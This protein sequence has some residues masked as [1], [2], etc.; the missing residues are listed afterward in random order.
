M[1]T[2]IRV[3]RRAAAALLLVLLPTAVFG[4][5]TRFEIRSTRE[6]SGGRAF[7][8]AGPYEEVRGRLFFAV[9]PANPV[10]RVVVDLD[11]APKVGGSRVEFSAD[12]VICRPRDPA[13]GNGVALIDVVN[14]GNQTIISGFNRP[15]MGA[16]R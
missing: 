6:L 12:V 7:G 10:N 9:A 5:V 13:K 15:G 14:R 3:A 1:R 11:K 2:A 8:A 4:E 16:D